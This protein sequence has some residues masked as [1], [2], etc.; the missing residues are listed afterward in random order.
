MVDERMYTERAAP[1]VRERKIL[2]QGIAT[3]LWEAGPV[4]APTVLYLHGAFMGNPWLEA[5]RSLAR[6][7]HIFAPDL[8]GFGRTKRPE[9]LNDVSDYTLFLRDLLTTLGISQAH[10]VGYDLGG[11]LAAE[12]AVWY[13]ER[14]E[15]LV[16]ASA[17]G[18][19]VRGQPIE[20]V[21]ARSPRQLAALTFENLK[22][23]ED[24][25]PASFDDIE[26]QVTQ[27]RERTALAALAWNPT[28]DPRLE[29]RLQHVTTP[30]LIIWGEQD[31][32]IPVAYADAYQCALPHASLVKL[33]TGHAPLFEQEALWSQNVASF[34]LSTALGE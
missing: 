33:P 5:H 3:H 27:Y 22:A 31:R 19:R 24:Y 7:F 14:I 17:Y 21:F 16:L 25:L 20:D 1:E 26:Y 32:V 13:H 8:P 15:K 12:L 18:L 23:V 30:T 9:W 10:V 4:D 11:W 34:L 28:Y 2:I 29:R 6:H